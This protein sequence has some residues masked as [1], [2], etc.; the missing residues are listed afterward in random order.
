MTLY[1]VTPL[2]TCTHSRN[3]LKSGEPSLNLQYK[4]TIVY[5]IRLSHRQFIARTPSCEK[6]VEILRLIFP[7][8]LFTYYAINF[9]PVSSTPS[10]IT[11]TVVVFRTITCSVI[12]CKP[13]PSPSPRSDYVVSKRSLKRVL[14]NWLRGHPC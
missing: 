8:G 2:T 12:V 4:R 10:V 9:L 13:P 14:E 7:K 5:H 11:F 3:Y 1:T 6:G